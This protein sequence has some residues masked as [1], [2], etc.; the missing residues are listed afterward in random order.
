[1]APY[2]P[3]LYLPRGIYTQGE[4]R[5][6]ASEGAISIC[7]GMSHLLGEMVGLGTSQRGPLGLSQNGVGWAL[8]TPLFSLERTGPGL[9]SIGD[10]NPTELSP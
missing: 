2:G 4:Q 10:R 1:M 3:S 9:Q 8:A 5:G 7:A 6:D